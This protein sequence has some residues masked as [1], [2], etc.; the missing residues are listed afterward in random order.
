MGLVAIVLC[1]GWWWVVVLGLSWVDGDVDWI[2][3]WVVVLGLG[4]FRLVVGWLRERNGEIEIR[5]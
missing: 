3:W 4:G 5:E 1:L 2:W